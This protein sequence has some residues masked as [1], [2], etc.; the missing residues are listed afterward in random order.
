MSYNIH[1][2]SDSYGWSAI[3]DIM[4]GI[5][6]FDYALYAYKKALVLDE[7][8][9]K[10][11]LGIANCYLGQHRPERTIPYL[12]RGLKL[13][14]P[15][16]YGFLLGNSYFDLGDFKSAIYY[17]KMV[18]SKNKALFLEAQDNIEQ[19][20][21]YKEFLKYKKRKKLK[22]ALTFLLKSETEIYSVFNDD[23][24]NVWY[25]VGVVLTLK[26]DF[27]KAL[28]YFKKSLY[29]DSKDRLALFAIGYCYSE[30][31]ESKSSISYYKRAIKLGY[32]SNAIYNL[33]NSYFDLGYY[34][35]AIRCYKK[36]TSSDLKN[37]ELAKS[38][39]RRAERQKS[40]LRGK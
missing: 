28:F 5:N 30:L 15:S 37:C 18:D 38:N 2:N 17:Y 10:C 14:S 8:N 39:I 22:K 3:G 4:L 29:F 26:N 27:K 32:N 21:K 40:K 31:G 16:K 19:S 9:E 12:K 35:E 23:S 11:Y 34:D 36:I 6:R 13:F 7:Y 1:K 24:N 25:Q 33:A 20:F